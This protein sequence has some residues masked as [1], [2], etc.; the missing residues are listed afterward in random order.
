MDGLLALNETSMRVRALWGTKENAGDTKNRVASLRTLMS[1]VVFV[2]VMF[3]VFCCSADAPS[4]M[5]LK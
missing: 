4:Q 5:S 1:D 2:D 3:V